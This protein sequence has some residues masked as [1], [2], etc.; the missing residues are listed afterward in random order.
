MQMYTS[1]SRA[2][3]WMAMPITAMFS[4]QTLERVTVELC[5]AIQTSQSVVLTVIHLLGW[6]RWDSGFIPMDQLLELR[7]MDKASM[8]TGDPVW[9]DWTGG[10]IPH[11]Q[12]GYFVVKYLTQLLQTQEFVSRLT[13]M[14]SL[15]YCSVCVCVCVCAYAATASRPQTVNTT[16]DAQS[17]NY[18]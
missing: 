18:D 12:L 5:S 4:S 8:S 2:E 13:W 16:T 14:V 9:C 7:A 10:E 17:S 11:L 15:I 6:E 3:K 1:Q